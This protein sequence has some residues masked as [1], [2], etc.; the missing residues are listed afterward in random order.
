MK[1]YKFFIFLFF[2]LISLF[3]FAGNGKTPSKNAKPAKKTTV[4]D[5][6]AVKGVS[7]VVQNKQA[8]RDSFERVKNDARLIVLEKR[9][10]F[11]PITSKVKISGI[12]KD[13]DKYV[14]P[15]AER[16]IVD[17]ANAFQQDFH[18]KLRVTSAMRPVSDQKKLIPKNGNAAP[19]TGQKQSLHSTGAA[20]DFGKRGMS[21]KEL[22]WMRVYLGNLKDRHVAYPIEEFSKKHPCFHVMFFKN[23]HKVPQK[24]A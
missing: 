20:V 17:L 21:Q 12:K 2:S 14:L 6:H 11:V 22:N 16:G 15:C 1:S 23:Y 9:G 18:K 24:V 8:D 10:R 5:L 19:A 13:I 7:Q 4:P 3:S